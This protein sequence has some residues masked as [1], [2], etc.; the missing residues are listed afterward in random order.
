MQLTLA[1]QSGVIFLGHNMNT[2]CLCVW[3]WVGSLGMH[4]CLSF[5]QGVLASVQVQT[6]RPSSTSFGLPLTQLQWKA[7]LHD[8]KANRHIL[9]AVSLPFFYVRVCTRIFAAH[10]MVD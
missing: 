5:L 7:D 2:I 6:K 9:V 10:I 8:W 4:V 3:A 1:Q